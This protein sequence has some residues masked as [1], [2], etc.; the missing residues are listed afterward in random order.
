MDELSGVL[1]NIN[2][3][4][5]PAPVDAYIR[6]LKGTF[7]FYDDL[8]RLYRDLMKIPDTDI[9]GDYYRDLFLGVVTYYIKEKYS[10]FKP[11]CLRLINKSIDRTAK[12]VKLKAE[13]DSIYKLLLGIKYRLV[14]LERILFLKDVDYDNEV[15][16]RSIRD[17]YSKN[18]QI[19]TVRVF[20]D[21]KF[22]Q[23][24]KTYDQLFI[25]GHGDERGSDLGGKNVTAKW[26]S[27]KMSQPDTIVKVLGVFS[28]QKNLSSSILKNKVDYFIT[29]SS[30]SSPD[31]AEMFLFGFFQNY[32]KSW[33]IKDSFEIAGVAPIFRASA[34][35][36]MELFERGALISRR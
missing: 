4:D 34:N 30:I 23:A 17:T 8:F 18:I 12:V 31:Y 16:F 19:K 20:N 33:R 14:R 15:F 3:L 9:K 26:L 25:L 29:D 5:I 24:I 2:K 32:L 36:R 27:E 13:R 22:G 1:D 10:N 6:D 28:C 7:N 35:L 11:T 21:T